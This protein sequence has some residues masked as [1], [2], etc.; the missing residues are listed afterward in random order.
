[1]CREIAFTN[2]EMMY[3]NLH[4]SHPASKASLKKPSEIECLATDSEYLIWFSQYDA[5]DRTL[6]FFR[7]DDREISERGVSLF[8]WVIDNLLALVS[9]IGVMLPTDFGAELT[10]DLAGMESLLGGLADFSLA[11]RSRTL[12]LLLTVDVDLPLKNKQRRHPECTIESNA[13]FLKN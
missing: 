13:F 10:V 4:T 6:N 3:W 5:E 8:R 2:K 12:T 7:L 9:E 11:E 1:M